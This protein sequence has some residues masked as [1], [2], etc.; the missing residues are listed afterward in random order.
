MQ[1][2]FKTDG[3]SM[4]D[5][6]AT[7]FGAKSALPLQDLDL[8]LQVEATKRVLKTMGLSEL[9]VTQ[10]IATHRAMLIQCVV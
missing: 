6:Y 4:K 1:T 8:E 5:N 7:L 10:I 3:K 9:L 2:L